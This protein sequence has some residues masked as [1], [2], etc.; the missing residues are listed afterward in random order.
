SLPNV[1]A[2]INSIDTISGY[3]ASTG[4]SSLSNNTWGFRKNTGTSEDPVYT[5]W[6][7]VGAK[8]STGT[9]IDSPGEGTGS[10]CDSLSYPLNQSGCNPSSYR[11]YNINVGA[12]LTSSLPAGTYTND[13]VFSATTKSEGT[14]YTMNFN[15]NGG[16]AGNIINPRIVIAGLSTI[17]PTS[18]FTKDGYGIK[19]WAFKAG[20]TPSTANTSS[21]TT[22]YNAG[23]SVAI[24]DLL[25]A[26]LNAGQNPSTNNSFTVYAVW[27]TA[28]T[29]NFNKNSNEAIGSM[30]PDTPI[31]QSA[32]Y[33]IPTSSFTREG[34][35]FIGWALSSSAATAGTVAYTAGQTPTVSSLITAA[36]AA[37]QSVSPGT[38]G[39]ITL[40]AVW[41]EATVYMQNFDCNSRLT[42]IGAS[43]TV[44][45]S[46][47][48]TDY[49]VKKLQ[50]GKCWMIENLTISATNMVVD[51]LDNTNTNIPSNDS[52]KYYLP[53][54][55]T[56]YGTA[57]SITNSAVKTASDTLDFS[58]S[59]SNQPQIGYKAA[60]STDN[61]TGN[62]VPENTA[63][64]PY[65]TASLGFSYYGGGSSYGSSPRD[66]CPK[67]WRL[68]KV[69]D[70]GA[71]V[72]ASSS[73]SA[74]L[75]RAYNGSATWQGNGD[76]NYYYYTSDTTIRQN[77][78]SGDTGSIDRYG[79][80]GAAGFTYAG[81]YRS[82]TLDLVGMYGFHW[83]SS[84]YN[85]TFSYSLYFSTV[86]DPQG[87]NYK[88][89]GSAVRCISD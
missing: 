87:I 75:A 82:T 24:N 2:T 78:I 38:A 53:P 27:E 58:D 56:R 84:V 10:Y 77:M 44:R 61:S 13:I 25:T 16:N 65:Y 89:F 34:Y 14:K 1:D 49:V 79:N 20:V 19:G 7:A 5:N 63:Y 57:N 45:D 76:T 15:S 62:P 81:S 73:E 28:Y 23:Q 69:S 21:D 50:D 80:N 33:T 12:K 83:S 66:I 37:G 51:S 88:Y 86:V 29:I 70:I 26:A 30:N 85:T 36:Q 35:N 46:R 60:G 54:R 71:S 41:E 52:T 72:V 17:L 55:N 67:E 31:I 11:T 8:D 74:N 47:D 18:G 40:Y 48:N 68:P 39:T 3:D 64:Y 43:M 32:T 59:N 9:V 4:A 6:Y 42:S 22:M